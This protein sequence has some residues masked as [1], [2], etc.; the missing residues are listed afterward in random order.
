ML[1][2]RQHFDHDKDLLASLTQILHEEKRLATE[3]HN[4]LIVMHSST[5]LFQ[6]NK[7]LS[8]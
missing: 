7:K 1:M 8:I 4:T 6:N 3:A 5:Q 2:D